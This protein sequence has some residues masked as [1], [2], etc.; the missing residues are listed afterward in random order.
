MPA[1]KDERVCVIIDWAVHLIMLIMIA[2]FRFQVQR[3]QATKATA[4]MIQPQ[5]RSIPHRA[6]QV[7]NVSRHQLILE[8]VFVSRNN[9]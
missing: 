1:V 9:A 4:L 3:H 2:V 6:A 8:R 5:L 7:S